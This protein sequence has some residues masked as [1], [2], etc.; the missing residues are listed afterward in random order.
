VRAVTL[1]ARSLPTIAWIVWL[2]VATIV[3][4][5]I[6]SILSSCDT[7]LRSTIVRVLGG[8]TSEIVSLNGDVSLLA[9]AWERLLLAH[10]V[11]YAAWRAFKAIFLR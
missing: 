4:L 5:A 9:W 1:A 2:A 8:Y 11:V 3:L 10:L 6:E 7:P